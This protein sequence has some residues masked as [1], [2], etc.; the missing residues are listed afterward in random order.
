MKI[1][2]TFSTIL[3]LCTFTVM[4]DLAHKI[5]LHLTKC[6][7]MEWQ[8][9]INHRIDEYQCVER[10][11]LLTVSE[12]SHVPL[13]VSSCW[14]WTSTNGHC[15]AVKIV[16]RGTSLED[17]RTHILQREKKTNLK[18]HTN[19]AAGTWNFLEFCFM[20][21]HT[22][23]CAQKHILYIFYTADHITVLMQFLQN[24]CIKNPHNNNFK[25]PQNPLFIHFVHLQL[26]NG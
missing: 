7:R 17:V 8:Q 1:S 6:K 14:L 22:Y 4:P 18:I 10:V 12:L 2:T 13:Q 25:K 9:E 23:M 16:C 5:Y 11:P 15:F 3:S 24:C 26:L 21:H 20:V 19:S